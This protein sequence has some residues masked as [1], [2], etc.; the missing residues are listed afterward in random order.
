M[1]L[2]AV[3]QMNFSV[4]SFLAYW[5]NYACTKNAAKLGDWDRKTVQIFQ[6]LAPILIIIGITFCPELPRRMFLLLLLLL[7]E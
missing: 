5:I 2:I 3:R 1:Q 7:L 6:L 4:G